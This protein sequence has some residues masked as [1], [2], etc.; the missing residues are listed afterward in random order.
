MTRK[1]K[2]EHIHDLTRQ[3]MKRVKKQVERT[4]GPPSDGVKTKSKKVKE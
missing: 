1:S 3:I 4:I 2:T